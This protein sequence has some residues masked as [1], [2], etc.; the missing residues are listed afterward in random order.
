M[1]KSRNHFIKLL[2]IIHHDFKDRDTVYRFQNDKF[3]ML[4]GLC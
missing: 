1:Y 2:N 3:Y 4:E